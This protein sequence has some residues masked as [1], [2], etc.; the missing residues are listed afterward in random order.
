M[1]QIITKDTTKEE[2][3][4]LR[5]KFDVG[6]SEIEKGANVAGYIMHK[7]HKGDFASMSDFTIHKLN[8]Y[9]NSLEE[10]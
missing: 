3:F 5:I 2:F 9:F 6:P 8:K 10:V 1:K 4:D 7:A